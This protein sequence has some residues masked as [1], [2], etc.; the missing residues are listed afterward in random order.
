MVGQRRLK[1]LSIVFVV[2]SVL[3]WAVDYLVN[4]NVTCAMSL[5][6]GLELG[7]H[8]SDKGVEQD[9]SSKISYLRLRKL[10]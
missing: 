3:L 8:Y 2:L 6:R 7:A 4:S 1:R 9:I 10:L 5:D